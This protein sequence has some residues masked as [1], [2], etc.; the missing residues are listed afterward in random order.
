MA[1][2]DEAARVYPKRKRANVS[3]CESN[4]GSELEDSDWDVKQPKKVI[5]LTHQSP[6]S[7]T[8]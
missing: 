6:R 4:N 7:D 2:A 8:I 5:I 3:Y 1:T